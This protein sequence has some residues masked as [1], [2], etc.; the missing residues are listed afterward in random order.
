M[1]LNITSS[2]QRYKL[3]ESGKIF[4][5]EQLW[6]LCTGAVS[7]GHGAGAPLCAASTRPPPGTGAHLWPSGRGEPSTNWRELSRR[8]LRWW[9]WSTAVRGFCR[10]DLVRAWVEVALGHLTA[11][12]HCLGG[13]EM[14]NDG[15]ELKLERFRPELRTHFV[16][17]RTDSGTG[18]LESVSS[19]PHPLRF[20]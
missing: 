14:S 18:C 9:G 1:L 2:S 20:S 10:P 15:H 12:Q 4:P 19:H 5:G 8:P 6:E 3:L 13:G 17:T 11:P 16:P 7:A